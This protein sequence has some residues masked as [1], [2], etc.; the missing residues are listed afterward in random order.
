MSLRGRYFIDRVKKVVSGSLRLPV[1][2]YG[3]PY[4]WDAAYRSF[5]PQ[6]SYEWGDVSLEDIL[7]YKY[8]KLNLRNVE[9]GSSEAEGSE[10]ATTFGDTLGVAPIDNEK[11]TGEQPIL[12]LGCGNSRFGEEMVQEGWR[13]PIVQTDVSARVIEAMSHRC[14]ALVSNGKMSFVED[15]ATQ[16][17]AFRDDLLHGC[18][19]K[20]LMD[21]IFCADEFDQCASVLTSVNRVLRPG[22]VF[23]FLSFSR[24]EFLLSQVVQTER[25]RTSRPAWDSVEVHELSSIMLYRFQKAQPQVAKNPSRLKKR[26]S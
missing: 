6:D 17:S 13:G 3:D 12:M 23:V 4:Y 20:G 15:D 19:D 25:Y 21:A 5:G 7:S 14:S 26:R 18:L 1:P 11:A 24:P 10:M 16:L 2:P 9:E 8:H 22:G